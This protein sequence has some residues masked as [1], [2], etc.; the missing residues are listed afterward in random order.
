VKKNPTDPPLLSTEPCQGNLLRSE[1]AID[2]RRDKKVEPKGPNK[3]EIGL[4]GKINRSCREVPGKKRIQ[5][6]SKKKIPNR[7]LVTTRVELA[8]LA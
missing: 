5:K 1:S 7:T 2:S 4:R 3:N 6:K 8:T